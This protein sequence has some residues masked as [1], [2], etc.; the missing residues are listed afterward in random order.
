MRGGCCG[1]FGERRGEGK[2]PR[3]NRKKV[4]LHLKAVLK[5]ITTCEALLCTGIFTVFEKEKKRKE[6]PVTTPGTRAVP[7]LSSRGEREREHP[8]SGNTLLSAGPVE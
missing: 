6:L 3:G 4:Q 7:Y 1:L 2:F 5:R 8:D